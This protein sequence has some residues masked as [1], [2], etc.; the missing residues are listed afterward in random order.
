ME[1]VPA[2][3]V[4]VERVAIRAPSKVPVP[5]IVEPSIKVTVSVNVLPPPTKVVG[6]PAER[7]CLPLPPVT[8]AVN[9]TDWPNTEAVG[10]AAKVVTV[11]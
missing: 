3:R 5:S 10:E 2:D 9:V 4:E 6:L 7:F 8:E 11:A 1:C